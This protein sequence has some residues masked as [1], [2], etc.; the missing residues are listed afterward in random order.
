MLTKLRS[1]VTI[2]LLSGALVFVGVGG[3]CSS[4]DRTA[5]PPARAAPR[6]PAGAV[7]RGR[8][9]WCGRRHRWCGR[10][11]R[12]DG[13]RRYG[14]RGRRIG[15]PRQLAGRSLGRLVRPL[16][17]T[18]SPLSRGEVGSRSIR[19]ARACCPRPPRPRRE[20][21]RAALEVVI[22]RLLREEEGVL[23]VVA[24]AGKPLPV[25][26]RAQLDQR[27]EQELARAL[28]QDLPAFDLDA[29]VGRG[30]PASSQLVTR[31]ASGRLATWRSSATSRS[32]LP[33]SRSTSRNRS[34]NSA[35]V[36]RSGAVITAVPP[37]AS[38]RAISAGGG[39]RI[40]GAGD[41]Q[42]RH[43]EVGGFVVGGKRA[44]LRHPQ[45]DRGAQV[46]D[47][48]HLGARL[49]DERLRLVEPGDAALVVEAPGQLAGEVTGRA[50]DLDD[51]RA[52]RGAHAPQQQRRETR[53]VGGADLVVVQPR[54]AR[55]LLAATSLRSRL[56]LRRLPAANRAER[57]AAAFVQPGDVA[58]GEQ[59]QRGRDPVQ[60]VGEIGARG[61]RRHR[62]AR[63]RETRPAS[64]ARPRARWRAPATASRRPGPGARPGT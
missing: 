25:R 35:H 37:G 13:R 55:L 30:R 58:A 9:R 39:A 8:H 4:D 1:V 36:P 45:R 50:A 56:L 60:R 21:E 46:R 62:A 16:S 17:L 10:R 24:A 23:H 57:P 19:S 59:I 29:D 26:Q 49:A 3:G 6:A 18:L 2:G 63:R 40:G 14:G 61:R 43:R 7:V 11:H 48:V 20:R 54:E 12:W 27:R 28:E 52:G 22:D 38:T 31:A 34:R 5:A 33:L 32:R 51:A 42:V 53:R 15:R 41:G 47:A 44:R 64:P